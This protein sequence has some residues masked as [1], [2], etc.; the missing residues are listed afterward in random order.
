MS[1]AITPHYKAPR[2]ASRKGAAIDVEAGFGSQTP[3]A[4]NSP[5]GMNKSIALT[6]RAKEDINN[7]LYQQTH[8]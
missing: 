6:K 5:V 4:V 8:G 7:E 1:G 2:A 3:P